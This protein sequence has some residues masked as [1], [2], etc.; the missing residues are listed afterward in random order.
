MLKSR[1]LPVHPFLFTL[2]P[3]LY[4]YAENLGQVTFPQIYRAGAVFLILTGVLLASLWRIFRDWHLAGMLV[5]L[6]MILFFSF[7]HAGKALRDANWSGSVWVLA[8][9]WGVIFCAGAALILWKARQRADLTRILN[10]S[11]GFLFLVSG[12]TIFSAGIVHPVKAQVDY[13]VSP[14][15]ATFYPEKDLLPAAGDVEHPPDIYYIILDGYA[16]GSVLQ[17]LYHLD[18]TPFL[19]F[20]QQKGFQ[21]ADN[22]HTNYIQTILSLSSSLNFAYLDQLV[23]L[24]PGTYSRE[25]VDRLLKNSRVQKFL[26]SKGYQIITLDSGYEY[27]NLDE[28]DKVVHSA[29]SLNAYEQ[30][31]LGTTL[32]MPWLDQIMV[33]IY[34][35]E[36][37]SR[38]LALAGVAEMSGPKFVFVHLVVPHP[39]FVFKRDGGETDITFLGKNDGSHYKEDS[40]TYRV[41]YKEQ[42][43]YINQ[44]TEEMIE[45]ILR[46]A[47]TPPVILL[48]GDH[49]PGSYLDWNSLENTCVRERTSILNALYLPDASVQIP[50][51]LT[52]VNSFRIVLNTYFGTHL[53]LA[54]NR[55]YYSL[56]DDPYR[57]MEV[58]GEVDSCAPLDR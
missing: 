19:D 2:Y 37:L 31:L 4:L 51:D 17:D 3:L 16:Q 56:W 6:F 29:F 53:E 26:R 58:S 12:Y 39:P 35:E 27:T 38:F 14:T 15:A 48:Q 49:G 54:A 43:L 25:P 13:L 32:A 10:I 11:S 47:K 23:T 20:L 52:P 33:K 40:A 41:R 24:Y 57:F 7:G 30:N 21:I 42:L 9:I 1:T 22:S 46:S 50:S 55:T 8:G 36:I 44:L 18:N 5:S 45:G 34:R 28:A